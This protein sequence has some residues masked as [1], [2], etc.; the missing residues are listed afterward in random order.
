[1]GSGHTIS[2]LGVLMHGCLAYLRA[3][4]HVRALE[5]ISCS[6]REAPLRYNMPTFH[7]Q[8][9]ATHCLLGVIF[10]TATLRDVAAGQVT[11]HMIEIGKDYMY[12]TL[13]HDP[14][15]YKIR[16]SKSM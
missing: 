9:R 3:V 7:R 16:V 8:G 5:L 2:W 4:V 15:C 13:P 11:R 1:M 6:A 14:L 12:F 10:R